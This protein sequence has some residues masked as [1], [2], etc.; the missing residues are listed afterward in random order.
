VLLAEHKQLHSEQHQQQAQPCNASEVMQ[1][2]NRVDK[3]TVSNNI[4]Q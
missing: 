2:Q 3:V 1:Q 4:A